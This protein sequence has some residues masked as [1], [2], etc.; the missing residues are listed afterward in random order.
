MHVCAE[1]AIVAEESCRVGSHL[2]QS[3]EGGRDFEYH[4]QAALLMTDV[5][6]AS[7]YRDGLAKPDI[8]ILATHLLM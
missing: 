7:H 4:T 8:G 6:M 2:F 5:F 3:D 1:F